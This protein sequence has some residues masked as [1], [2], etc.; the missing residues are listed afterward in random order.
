[1]KEKNALFKAEYPVKQ[2]PKVKAFGTRFVINSPDWEKQ[3]KLAFDLAK[4]AGQELNATFSLG[5][6]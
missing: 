3:V 2:G 5:R 6:T 1:M 4:S